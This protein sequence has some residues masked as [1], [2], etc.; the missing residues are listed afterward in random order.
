MKCLGGALFGR[1]A[2]RDDGERRV[3][4]E[5]GYDLDAVLSHDDLMRSDLVLF[6]A[7]GITD[8]PLLRGVRF[9]GRGA[10]TQSMSMRSSSGTVRVVSAEHTFSKFNTIARFAALQQVED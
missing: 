3:A 4:L 5:Q 7:T 9:T 8:G 6:A 2:P 1:L 10:T